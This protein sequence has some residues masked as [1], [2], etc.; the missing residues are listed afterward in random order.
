MS[1]EQTLVSGNPEAIAELIINPQPEPSKEEIK[2]AEAPKP[3]LE[4]KR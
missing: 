4:G 3:R 1:K 2:S